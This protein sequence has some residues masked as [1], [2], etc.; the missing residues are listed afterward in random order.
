MPLYIYKIYI[1]EYIYKSFPEPLNIFI[2]RKRLL[3]ESES[4]S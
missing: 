2:P 1:Y 3:E 4:I